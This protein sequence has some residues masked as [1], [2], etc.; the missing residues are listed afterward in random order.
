MT[1]TEFLQLTDAVFARIESAID[2]AGLDA[3][4]HTLGNVLEIEFDDGA[5]IIVNRHSSNHELWIA[6][7]SGGYHFALRD[8]AWIAARDGAEFY[9]TLNRAVREACGQELGLA[10]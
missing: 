7:K 2:D 5:K 10:P 6:A 1:D 9:A 3:D 4:Y 8:S